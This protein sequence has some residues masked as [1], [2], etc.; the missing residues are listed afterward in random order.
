MSNWIQLGEVLPNVLQD[1]AKN[2]GQTVRRDRLPFIHGPAKV[3]F[4]NVTPIKPANWNRGAAHPY[5]GGQQRMR[6]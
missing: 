1:A 5:R 3:V 4:G 6:R 2:I